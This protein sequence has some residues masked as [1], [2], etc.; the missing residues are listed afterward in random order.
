M[1]K[2]LCLTFVLQL[3]LLTNAHAQFVSADNSDAELCT[4]KN[5]VTFK[6]E[7]HGF[8]FKYP[9][10]LEK[11]MLPAD[12]C[13]VQIGFDF[14]KSRAECVESKDKLPLTA[15]IYSS[16][17]ERGIKNA[18]FSISEEIE[19]ANASRYQFGLGGSDVSAVSEF[20]SNDCRVLSASHSTRWMCG[21]SQG[22][23]S[24]ETV[25]VNCSEKLSFS[26]LRIPSD[27][28]ADPLNCALS[29]I[30]RTIKLITIKADSASPKEKAK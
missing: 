6:D 27:N 24:S 26:L 18:G 19:E 10:G 9:A 2:K 20:N 12:S 11:V 15:C 23:R 4:E 8:E 29:T 17:F 22:Y 30:T 25:Y 7:Q 21:G 3:F 16:T 1:K 13:L 14:E 28:E 5:L